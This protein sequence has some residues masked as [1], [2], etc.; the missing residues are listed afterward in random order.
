MV[1]ADGIVK[2]CDIYKINFPTEITIKIKL[3]VSIKIANQRSALL[4]F[5]NGINNDFEFL[6]SPFPYVMAIN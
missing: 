4:F 5:A 1:E 6:K 3:Y 2:R